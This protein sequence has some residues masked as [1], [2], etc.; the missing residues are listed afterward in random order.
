[1]QNRLDVHNVAKVMQISQWCQRNLPNDDWDMEVLTIFPTHY[2]FE[3]KDHNM[4]IMA[5]LSS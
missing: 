2:K 1:M 5:A 4:R 3:F